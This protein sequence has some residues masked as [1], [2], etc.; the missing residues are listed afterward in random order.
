MPALYGFSIESGYF[1]PYLVLALQN[2]F[3]NSRIAGWA[4]G[5]PIFFLNSV[6]AAVTYRIAGKFGGGKFGES[7][8]I[9]QTKTIQISTLGWDHLERTAPTGNQFRGA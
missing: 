7:S 1:G 5:F 8:V 6:I 3:L 2:D 4:Q 9:R